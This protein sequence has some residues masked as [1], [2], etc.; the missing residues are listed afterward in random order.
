V[1]DARPLA[2]PETARTGVCAPAELTWLL[3]PPA[4]VVLLAAIVLLGPP[5]GHLL[6]PSSVPTFSIPFRTSVRPEPTE[7]A[8][9]LLALLG[10]LLLCGAVALLARRAAQP[11]ASNRQVRV[12]VQASQAL[13]AAFLVATVV[14]QQVAV[15]H[16]E[17]NE[18]GF[19]RAY[20]TLPALAFAV[21]A[22]GLVLA[23]LRREAAWQRV[24]A[25]MRDT[26]R[27]TLAARGIAVVFTV[28]WLLT[29]INSDQSAGA[30]NPGVWINLSYWSDETFAVLD[31]RAPLVTF[32]PQYAQLWPYATA[33]LMLAFGASI[34]TYTTVMATGTA[35]ALLGIY[36]VFRRV[37]RSAL[38]ALGLYLP[39]VAT[40]FFTEHGPMDNRYG[41]VDAFSMFPMRYGGPYLLAWL[42]ARAIDGAHPPRRWRWLFA[43]AGI[44]ALNNLE[45]G[46][47]ALAATGV[48]LL[49]TL[50]LRRE[51][52]VRLIGEAA[53]GVLIATAAVSLLTLAVAGSLPHFG[54]LL[55]F[56]RIFGVYGFGMLPM[57]AFGFQLAVY[58]TF[59][60][61]IVV[62]IVRVLGGERD[63]LLTAMLAW[64]GVFGLGAGSYFVGRSHP[65]VLIDLFS[66]WALALTLLVVA[67]ARTLRRSTR[68]P[69]IAELAV[70]VGF[71]LAIAS[72]AQIPTPWSQI[73]RLGH[74]MRQYAFPEPIPT[75]FVD[76]V[77]TRG[78]H[79]VILVPLGHRI[80]YD[81]GLVNVSP[82]A[83]GASMP[84]VE[85]FERT[86]RALRA[87]GGH[88][89]FI[90]VDPAFAERK[91]RLI[92]DG[93][94]LVRLVPKAEI[95][96][97]SDER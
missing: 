72:I 60:A 22:A 37:T 44:V 25:W 50:P 75:G 57:R 47:P 85:Q 26:P 31:G 40:S 42:T 84:L 18:S 63:R 2:R 30:A 59:A 81:L 32:H 62:A 56:P 93:F 53:L 39:F 1:P 11:A 35:A 29:A 17:A 64:A 4:A 43:V 16:Y 96:E 8:R 90:Y 94:H 14:A 65:E 89:M 88:K 80:A 70:L 10:P 15:Y 66:A 12:A 95:A 92:A 76:R 77:T 79:V 3:A 97:F 48:A 6:T 5:L 19:R 86:V 71:G 45:F 55:E 27:R 38:A 51:T 9:Y 52:V 20:F 87:S 91:Q 82:Y 54:Q 83:T 28:V 36:G 74:R 58:V 34:T 7:H 46:L 78:E 67:T 73:D 33:G 21:V 24:A 68:R 49:A 13:A 69:A 41:P 23:V 61:A